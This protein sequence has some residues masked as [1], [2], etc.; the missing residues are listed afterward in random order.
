MSALL[1]FLSLLVT[2][3]VT[4][5]LYVQS[6]YS[7][8][9]RKGVPYQTPIFPFGNLKNVFL[10]KEQF[11]E[12]LAD[13]YKS[14][15]EP[16]I[17]IYTALRPALLIRDP[18]II[19]DMCIKNFHSF[20]HRILQANVE[21]DPMADNLLL[22]KGEKWKRLRTQFT[23]AFSSGKL[24]GMFETIV[25]CGK[26]LDKHIKSFAISGK[27]VEMRDVFARFAT[28][29]IASVAFGIEVDSIENP[30]CEFRTYGQKIFQP[31][32]KN[33]IRATTNVF[34]PKLSKLFGFRFVDKDIGDFMIETVR[35]NLEYREK[36]NVTRKDFF[37]LLMQLRNTGKILDDDDWST[38]STSNKKELTLIELAAQA[39][40]FF[41]GGFESS[42][43]T[44]SFC[45]YELAKN[46][47]TQQKAY[48]EI[49]DVL[50]KHDGKLTYD[51]VADM[52]FIESCIDESLRLHPPFPIATRNCS[53]NYQ[54]PGTNV[55]I[56]EGTPIFF[57]TIGLQ[58]DE[59]Y[60]AE[61]NKFKPERY[62]SAQSINRSFDEMPNLV[63]GEGPRNCIAKRLGKLQSKIAIILLIEKFIFELDDQHKNTELTLDPRSIVLAPINGLNFKVSS[64]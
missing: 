5:F 21:A 58:Y 57:S 2:F 20:D 41:G 29:V 10:Q 9:K 62:S 53:R 3:I 34:I 4:S 35:Q 7:Y 32:L 26:S 18:K 54:I 28:N 63:F 6:K 47:E 36:N 38:K 50:E 33:T 49:V 14:T 45:L 42:S 56:E 48:E 46:P 12:G 44:M 55:T 17:G 51:S 60:Y 16:F 40:L 64:R 15:S 23:P 1:I 59:K 8:W 37:Q 19:K 27:S 39:V 61:P 25:A 43:S 24:K 22:Q 31:S 52:K 30:E 11:G 13:I